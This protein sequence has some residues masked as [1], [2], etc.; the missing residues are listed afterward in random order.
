[1]INYSFIIPHKNTPKLLQRCLDSI[2]QRDDVEVIVVDNNSSLDI[3]D[4]GHY[5]GS[6]RAKIIKDNNS[7]GP[8]GARNTG[9][10]IAQGKWVLFADADD[11]YSVGF[12]DTLD[13]YI[14]SD[15]DVIFFNFN[16]IK[17]GHVAE[18][19]YSLNYL[20]RYDPEDLAFVQM[21]K[22][23]FPVPWNKMTKRD[24]LI[25]NNVA[26]KDCIIGEDGVFSFNIGFNAKSYI[27]DKSR[28]YNYT[29]NSNS[30]TNNVKNNKEYYKCLFR[31]KY[32]YNEFFK[33]INHKEWEQSV[34]KG[35]LSILYKKGFFQFLLATRVLVNNIK[36][37]IVDRTEIVDLF[38]RNTG[39]Y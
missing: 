28:L 6:N 9:L 14:L 26:F 18:L 4:F 25:R 39:K 32:Q 8:G 1:M 34:F 29:I 23:R 13:H 24:F 10:K 7:A 38:C 30:I 5:P 3:V 19:P 27:I 37:F 17:D 12:L 22:F 16:M 15:V 20:D 11:Y 31:Q 35:L 36:S 21:L 2:P 33:F